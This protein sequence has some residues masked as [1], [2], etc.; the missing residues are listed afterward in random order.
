MWMIRHL[1]QSNN[2]AIVYKTRTRVLGETPPPDLREQIRHSEM[3]I[4]LLSHRL[5]DGTIA[6]NPYKK[7]QGPHWT[8]VSLAEIGYPPGDRSLLPMRDQF[9]GYLFAPHHLTP[10]QSLLIPGQED[11]FRRCASQEGY[12]IWY[13]LTLGLADDRTEELVRRLKRWQWPDGGWNCD[14]RPQADTSSFFESLMPLRALALHARLTGDPTS[15]KAAERAAELFLKRRLFRTLHDGTVMDPN[16]LQI[17]YPY[18][19]YY[20][21]LAG[22]V[23]MAEAGYI[24]DPRC[25]DALDWLESKRL[26]DG[27]FPLEKRHHQMAGTMIANGTFAD[28][29]PGGQTRHNEFVTVEA[30]AVLRA[31]NRL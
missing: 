2:P 28:W 21:I 5:A 17:H 20:S 31:A 16:F 23:V 18:F 6:T 27:G 24:Q 3:A 7:W 26:T 10:P 19:W 1:L 9:Y 11:R 12:A 22:L 25:S 13:S 30:L 15:R 14:K 29:G 4:R 8:L